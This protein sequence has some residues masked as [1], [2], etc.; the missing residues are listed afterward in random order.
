MWG[1]YEVW[2]G[3]AHRFMVQKQFLDT[4][5]VGYQCV[6]VRG[7]AAKL[8]NGCNCIHAVTDM[9]PIYPRWR[10]PARVLRQA[11]HREPRAALHALAHLDRPSNHA[12]LA[13]CRD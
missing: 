9:D 3:F 10:L 7:E 12:Q 8:G 13:V 5:A 1:P 6:D 2:H 4:G 11:G